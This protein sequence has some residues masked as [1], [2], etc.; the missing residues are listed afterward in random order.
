MSIRL[1]IISSVI[2][3]DISTAASIWFEVWG[4]RESGRRD[5]RFQSK[6]NQFSG[7]FFD[8]PGKNSYEVFSLVATQKIVFSP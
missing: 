3:H 1:N 6:K 2:Y 8:F 7:N 5:F 4:G